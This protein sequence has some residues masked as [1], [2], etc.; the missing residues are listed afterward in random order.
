[1]LVSVSVYRFLKPL[2]FL[3][4]PEA[5]HAL[6]TVF[7]RLVSW[8]SQRPRTRVTLPLKVF[9]ID[10]P[11]PVGLAA[12]M[13]K[14]DVVAPAWF[15]LGFGW[16]EIG[17]ITPRPQQ[18][19]PRPRLFRLIPDKA[20]VNRMGFNNAGAANVAARLA[21]LRPQPGPIC[22]NVGRNKDTPNDRAADDYVAALREL[23]PYA[24]L[25]TIN[26]S[27]P[28]TPGLRELQ[29]SIAGLVRRARDALPRGM[30][31]L[32]KLSPDEPDDRLVEIARAAE[33]AG[34]DGI[35]AT[36]TTVQHERGQGGLSGAPLR[37]RALHV[38]KL[39]H[40]N[41]KI[42]IVGVG[43]ILSAEDAYARIRAGASLIQIYTALIYDGPSTPKKIIRGLATLLQRDGLTLQ[44]AIGRD[45]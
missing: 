45:S 1:M 11:S 41:V 14:G 38:C 8:L 3:L 22:V 16:V 9:G 10:F 30:P 31:L 2:L 35:I 6:A 17:T 24:Q 29:G 21:R 15:R 27:S 13:D 32:V 44:E 19:N 5:A 28:N 20:L 39:L 34:A 26:V 40:R 43:G 25:A 7:L 18:G 12:G 37:D 42:P 4:P 36:N 33:A 23:A